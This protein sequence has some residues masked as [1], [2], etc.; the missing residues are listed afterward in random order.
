LTSPARGRRHLYLWVLAAGAAGTWWAGPGRAAPPP[1]PSP[2]SSPSPVASAAPSRDEAA[3][4]QGCTGCHAFPP[5]EILPRESWTASVYEMAGLSMANSGVPEGA[6]APRPADLDVDAIER[7]YR[8]RA[9]VALPTPEPWPAIGPEAARFTRHEL[10]PAGGDTRPAISNVRFLALGGAT[11]D[12]VATDMTHGMVLRGSPA[13][14]ERGLA[15]VE[16]VTAPC[17][18]AAVDLDRDGRL[19]LLVADL[20]DVPPADHLKGSVVWLQGLEGG[21]Y[22]KRAIATGLPRVADVEAGDFDAD[23]DLDLAVA[24]FGWRQVG[25]LLLL[26]NRTTDWSAPTF[27]PRTLDS[28]TGAI[29][30]PFVD[31]DRDGRADLV[32]VF[33]QHHETVVAF[34]NTP[35]GVRRETIYAA[36]HPAWGSSG[37]EVV[38]LDGDRDLDVVLV[39]GDMLDDFLLKPYHGIQWLENRG[40]FP[41]VEHTLASLSGVMGSRAADLDGDGDLDIA[42]VAYVPE[43]RRADQGPRPALPSLVWLEQVAPGRFQRHT[44]EVGGRHVSVDAADYD[45]DGDVDL[46][47][48]SFGSGSRAWVEV[49]ENGRR[50][51]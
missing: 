8:S 14:P 38:D 11:P 10:A 31:L 6:A 18:T 23:G 50:G 2:P 20:G 3:A 15:V 36:P 48:G 45:R 30:V 28:R 37:I 47:V 29:H 27:A 49:W 7:F 24:A 4:R 25:S 16:R 1:T 42:A 33:S 39:H 13:A 19:D 32:T 21:G 5:P 43:P 17:H 35:T 41:F 26:E 22:R 46:V 9:P 40:S 12:V 34:L 44:L 51:K